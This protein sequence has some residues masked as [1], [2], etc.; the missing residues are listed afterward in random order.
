MSLF[1]CDK[2]INF[3]KTCLADVLLHVREMSISFDV[4]T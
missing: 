1:K 3:D 4:D 2:L